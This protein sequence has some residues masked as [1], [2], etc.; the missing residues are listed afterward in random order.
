MSR[1]NHNASRRFIMGE[2]EKEMVLPPPAQV[3]VVVRD[4]QKAMDYYSAVFGLGPFQTV[5]FAPAHHWLKGEPCPIRLKIG[6]CAWGPLQLELIEPLEGDGLHTHRWFLNEKGEGVQ[7]LGFIVDNYDQWIRYLETQ[8]IGVLMNAE[9]YV[10]GM[11]DVR[12]A[13]MQS[14]S[15]GGVLFELIEIRP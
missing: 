10:E 15:T 4:L 3:G 11:G 6:M 5:D 7:H 8:G 12:A 13:Y 14:D 1:V 9:T 2:E